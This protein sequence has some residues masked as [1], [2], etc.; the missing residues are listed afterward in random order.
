[1]EDGFPNCS[2]KKGSIASNTSVS[3]GVVAA[4]SK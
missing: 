3:M 2:L 1:M 4:L